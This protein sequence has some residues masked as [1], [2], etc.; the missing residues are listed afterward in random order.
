MTKEEIIEAIKALSKEELWELTWAFN[1][2]AGIVPIGRASV[3]DIQ[4]DIDNDAEAKEYSEAE[5][6]FEAI[7]GAAE[8]D[9][10]DQYGHARAFVMEELQRARNNTALGHLPVAH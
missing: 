3:A 1:D 5:K 4:E 2:A 8:L 7:R 10:S 6:F 9:W